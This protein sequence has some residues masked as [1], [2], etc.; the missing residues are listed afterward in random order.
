M[1]F[2]KDVDPSAAGKK[3]AEKRWGAKKQAEAAVV[4]GTAAPDEVSLLAAMRH[5]FTRP[6]RED[7]TE[8][9]KFCRGWM[10]ANPHGFGSKL[11]DL[12]AKFG[13]IG[14]KEQDEDQQA[15]AGTD[16][17]LACLDRWLQA[18]AEGRADD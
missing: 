15:D 6:A 1:A 4:E 11:A 12:E 10:E 13:K 3:S 5:A 16:A 18:R 8:Q 17:A 14:P 2:G 9:H 7:R